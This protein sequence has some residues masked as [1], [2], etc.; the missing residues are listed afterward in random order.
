MKRGPSKLAEAIVAFLL[1]RSCREEVLGD[2]YERYKSPLR[3]PR[4]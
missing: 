4:T 3:T 2:L 1:P